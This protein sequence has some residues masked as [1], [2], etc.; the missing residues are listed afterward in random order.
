MNV[1]Q[2]LNFDLKEL[3]FR[4]RLLQDYISGMTDQF[5]HDEYQE[6]MVAGIH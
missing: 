4:C 5:A 6:L 1:Q 2:A 3:Y